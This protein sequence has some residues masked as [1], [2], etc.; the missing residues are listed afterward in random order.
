MKSTRTSRIVHDR[1]RRPLRDDRAGIEDRNAVGHA[2]DQVEIVLDQDHRLAERIAQIAQ[3]YR[4]V[5]PLV[6]RQTRRRLVQQEHV[7][8]HRDHAQHFEQSPLRVRQEIRSLLAPPRLHI[9]QRVEQ[10]GGVA[11]ARGEV[12]ADL[13]VLPDRQVLEHTRR[14]ERAPDAEPRGAIGRQTRRV[15]AEDLDPAVDPRGRART[16][17]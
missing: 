17:R 6:R 4:E 8:I 1:V 7:T 2:P 13:Q 3:Q 10:P 5:T 14:L 16:R 9:A 15:V 11:P 12:R